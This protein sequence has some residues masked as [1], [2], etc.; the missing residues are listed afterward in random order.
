MS[1]RGTFWSDITR[2]ISSGG[3]LIFFDEAGTKSTSMSIVRV[4]KKRRKASPG[5][6]SFAGFASWLFTSTLPAL[7]ISCATVLRF[8]SLLVFRNRSRRTKGL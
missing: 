1:S 4:E 2:Y 8:T 5:P 7:H 3:T 6:I